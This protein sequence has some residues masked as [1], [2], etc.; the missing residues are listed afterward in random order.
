MLPVPP[1]LKF[2][3]NVH[4]AKQFKRFALSQLEI[5]KKQ[6]SFQ[7]LK[8]GVRRVSPFEGVLIEC[9]SKF[10]L[11]VVNVFVAPVGRGGIRIS[12]FNLPTLTV[13][14][15]TL[16]NIAG[17]IHCVWWRF[18]SNIGEFGPSCFDMIPVDDTF[19]TFDFIPGTKYISSIFVS[20][21]SQVRYYLSSGTEDK[22]ASVLNYVEM[23]NEVDL[24]P[25]YTRYIRVLGEQVIPNYIEGYSVS[26]NVSIP[27]IALSYGLNTLYTT[28]A[29]ADY[30]NHE[31]LDYKKLVIEDGKW[32]TKKSGTFYLLENY[33]RTSGVVSRTGKAGGVYSYI[34]VENIYKYTDSGELTELEGG[35]RT[36]SLIFDSYTVYKPWTHS[37]DT[38]NL[39]E[40]DT[41]ITS[42]VLVETTPGHWDYTVYKSV[43]EL[44]VGSFWDRQCYSQ[45]EILANKPPPEANIHYAYYGKLYDIQRYGVKYGMGVGSFL[46]EDGFP[47][48]I[49][50]EVESWEAM[51]RP[52]DDVYFVTHSWKQDYTK[53]DTSKGFSGGRNCVYFRDIGT[54]YIADPSEGSWR[55]DTWPYGFM[56]NWRASPCGTMLGVTRSKSARTITKLYSPCKKMISPAFSANSTTL[57]H[58]QETGLT[59]YKYSYLPAEDGERVEH[60]CARSLSNSE[61]DIT[62]QV[63]AAIKAALNSDI[64]AGYTPK[65]TPDEQ[66]AYC[67]QNFMYIYFE[68]SNKTILEQSCKQYEPT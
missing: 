62:D 1:R 20:E 23:V 7:G 21:F 35:E 67:K 31:L 28:L 61:H 48:T 18:D 42:Q 47:I 64:L 68:A 13:C 15:K 14:K 37:I 26:T 22:I 54:T 53:I 52:N 39:E 19:S 16:E 63:Y 56:Q 8:Q 3:G 6:M 30:A 44:K 25:V 51:I 40:I 57:A 49:D 4:A 58:D 65:M 27:Y 5:L 12:E 17:L 32:I 29:Y 36:T 66:T 24:P 10:G 2:H 45:I 55:S 60:I 11:H 34:P 43:G 41:I 59:F 33:T 50:N 9:V 38:E 46:Y